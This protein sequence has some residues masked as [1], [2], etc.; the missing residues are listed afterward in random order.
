MLACQQKIHF[1]L[2][3]SV[4]LLFFLILLFNITFPPMSISSIRFC[5]NLLNKLIW[6]AIKLTD[7]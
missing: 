4:A 2:T 7:L 5:I 3:Y 6:H 1:I